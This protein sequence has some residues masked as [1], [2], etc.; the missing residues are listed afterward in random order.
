MDAIY[1]II[2]G[3]ISC[4]AMDLWQRLLKLTYGIPPSNW[5]TVGR[6]LIMM[7]LKMKVYNPAIDDEKPYKNELLIGWLFHYF[8]AIIYAL[9]FFIMLN[10]QILNSSFYDGVMFGL[11][12]VIIPWFIFMPLFGKGFLGTKTPSPIKSCSL[13]VGSHAVIG[14]SIALLFQFFGY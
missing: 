8:I 2:V 1:V 7:I 4:F 9:T 3:I 10:K 14:I 5:A 13:A 11:I 12:S 6:W